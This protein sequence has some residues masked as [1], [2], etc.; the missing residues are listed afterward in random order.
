[1]LDLKH[2]PNPIA[3]EKLVFFLRRH[4]ITLLP[5]ASGFC[6]LLLLPLFFVAYFSAVQ[7]A[8]IEGPWLTVAVL[9]GS[10]FFLYAWLFLFQNFVDYYLDIWIV[11]TKRILNIEQIGLFGRTVSELRLYR[12]QDVTADVR[13]VLHTFLNYG[14]VHIQTAAEQ[15]RFEFEEVPHPNEVAKT[16]LE[17]SEIDRRSHLDDAV[18]DFALA[19][20]PQQ[21]PKNKP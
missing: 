18:E 10:L 19:D 1:M 7:P 17:L 9:G 11:T 6:I 12:I 13:G 2:L 3:D 5:L 21:K 8:W 16:I 14:N 4:P 20:H 15:M